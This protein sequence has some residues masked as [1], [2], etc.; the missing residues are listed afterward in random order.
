MAWQIA[1]FV[2]KLTSDHLALSELLFDGLYA[3]DFAIG[4]VSPK[5]ACDWPAISQNELLL[6][7]Y[8][9]E[10]IAIVHLCPRT[11]CNWLMASYV[12]ERIAIGQ[13]Y[14]RTDCYWPVMCQN[15]LLLARDVQDV[16][17]GEEAE[18]G[19]GGV[20]PGGHLRVGGR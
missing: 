10:R 12:P 9:P 11:D 5:T 15:G 16:T 18:G 3:K 4:H 20:D 2:R 6:A 14:P 17:C 1:E 19:V 8:V 7:S 13:L